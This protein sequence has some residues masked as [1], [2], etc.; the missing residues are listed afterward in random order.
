MAIRSPLL[1]ARSA[2]NNKLFYGLCY[3]STSCKMT[4]DYPHWKKHFAVR[5]ITVILTSKPLYPF[6]FYHNILDK[7]FLEA[8]SEHI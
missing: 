4:G 1:P 2:L 7:S 8:N 5:S 3:I 6:I